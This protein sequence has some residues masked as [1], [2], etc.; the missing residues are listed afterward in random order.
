MTK[1][2]AYT[3]QADQHSVEATQAAAASGA[4]QVNNYHPHAHRLHSSPAGNLDEHGLHY[5]LCDVEGN[6]IHPVFS[7]DAVESGF[8][9]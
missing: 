9:F 1:I 6:M 7:T 4:L 8:G 5:N 3:W 2:I